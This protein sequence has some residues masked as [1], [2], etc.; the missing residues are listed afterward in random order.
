MLWG[1]GFSCGT[2]VLGSPDADEEHLVTE[3]PNLRR[4]ADRV[5]PAACTLGRRPFDP[6]NNRDLS[7][8]SLREP[9]PAGTALPV[10][11]GTRSSLL[12]LSTPW[13]QTAASSALRPTLQPPILSLPP[14]PAP[15]PIM[16][17]VPGSC[18][19]CMAS[20]GALSRSDMDTLRRCLRPPT[21]ACRFTATPAPP[22]TAPPPP[23]L[24]SPPPGGAGASTSTA[25]ISPSVTLE[26]RCSRRP[27]VGTN[28]AS[29]AAATAAVTPD[30]LGLPFSGG[31][32][33]SSLGTAGGAPLPTLLS[34]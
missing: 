12:A 26:L 27:H 3:L 14:R 2:S 15:S 23:E 1:G 29:A 33:R 8:P 24:D 11:A 10:R 6:P 21:A 18:R 20:R 34:R 25:G 30:A 28:T 7:L 16:S 31:S 32:S 19:S 5:G 13:C 4:L 17:I 22:A 9:V